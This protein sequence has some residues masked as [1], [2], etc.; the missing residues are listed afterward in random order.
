MLLRYCQYLLAL[1]CVVFLNVANSFMKAD[2][3]DIFSYQYW[4]VNK[5]TDA[6]FSDTAASPGAMPD[7]VL[8]QGKD[9]SVL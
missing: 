1:G 6:I 9:S 7:S 2:I 8:L 3:V 4:K 5:Q